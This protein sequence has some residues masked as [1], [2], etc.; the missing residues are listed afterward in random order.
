MR[1]EWSVGVLWEW[2]DLDHNGEGDQ[3]R[4]GRIGCFDGVGCGRLRNSRNSGE[5]ILVNAE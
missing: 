1:G 4:P 2:D 3:H 5:N